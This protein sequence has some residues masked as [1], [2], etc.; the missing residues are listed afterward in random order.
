MQHSHALA[1]EPT[2]LGLPISNGKFAMW[3]FLSTEVM[4]FMGLIGSFIVLRGGAPEWPTQEKVG[5]VAWL[6][7][8]NTGVLIVS[9]A[10]M[11][12]ALAATARGD[13]TRQRPLLL[14]TIILGCVFMAVKAVEYTGKFQHGVYPGGPAAVADPA[15]QLFA[16]LYFILTGFHAIHVLGGIVMLSLLLMWS[17][18]GRLT[19]AEYET[20]ELIGLYWHFVDVVW[21]FLFPL[22]YLMPS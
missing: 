13:T 20:C 11:A 15:I 10:T 17:L 14:A 7:A 12:F 1:P 8:L 6:G 16:S 5:L 4:F 18:Q 21:V 22:L 19:P 9:S 3:L 2:E